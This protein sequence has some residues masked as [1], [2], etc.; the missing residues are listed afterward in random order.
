[1]Q[2]K[3]RIYTVS[4]LNKEVKGYLEGNPNFNELFLKGEISNINYYKSGHLYFTLKDKKSQ[5]KCAA[6]NYG[7]KPIPKDLKEG[8]MIKLFGDIT[9]YEARGDYQILVRHV[10]KQNTIGSLFE[11]LE[12]T[13]KEMAK[14][15]YF[16]EKYKQRLPK[17][18][19]TIGIV[20]SGT[21]AAVRDIIN[22]ARLRYPN[23]NIIVYPAKVQ[24]EGA[25]KEIIRGIETLNKIE[26]V[27]VII[28][29]RGGGSIEDLWCFN[30]KEVAL[31]YF[32]SKKPIVSAVG[33][34]I[35][36]LLTDFVADKRASTPTHASEI[37]VPEKLKLKENIADREKYLKTILL[38]YLE[39]KRMSLKQREEAY[40]ITG[41]LR[42]IK[43][44]NIEVVEQEER[45]NRAYS[46]YLQKKR[47]EVEL[48]REKLSGL[49]AKK[50]LDMGYSIT[51]YNGRAIKDSKGLEEGTIIET[52]LSDGR[53]KSSIKETE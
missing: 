32:N 27:D 13:K 21:G 3:E 37:I 30:E 22:T 7:Y 24:G 39:K 28:A 31:A 6:F 46:Y 11:Q 17:L 23:I 47:S 40:G 36:N 19:E 43:E 35:D 41:F 26:E 48:K 5:I 44:K 14:A 10:E 50:I 51:T 29:G 25:S 53:L 45:L 12:K 20:T 42:S 49:D 2:K 38:K 15:G 9:I 33:H 16:D 8:D 18:P 1:M 34:E 52:I 4:E